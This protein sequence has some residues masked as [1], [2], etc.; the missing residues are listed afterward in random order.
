MKSILVCLLMW[1]MIAC[2]QD[3]IPE[4]LLLSTGQYLGPG[5]RAQG[6]AG[7]YTGI[8]DDY[9]A[10]WW[11]PAG[12]A[13]IKRIEI[14]GSLARSGFAN[15][16]AWNNL[17]EM[18]GK[19]S[20]IRINN[21]GLVL[22]VPVY[23]GALSFAFGYSQ[24]MSFDRHTVTGHDGEVNPNFNE[25]EKGRL[26]FWTFASAVDVSPN[27]ALG[28]GIQYWSGFDD[29]SYIDQYASQTPPQHEETIATDLG[30]WGANV[31]GLFRAGRYGRIGAMYQAPMSMKLDESW[32]IDS[33][34]GHFDYRMTYPA[35]FRVGGSLAPGRWL[36]A[37]DVE[38]RDWTSLEF[39]SATPYSGVS[40]AQANQ[41][42]KDQY[43]STTRFSLGG[44]YLFPM[45]GVRARAGYSFAPS[46]YRDAGGEDNKNILGLGLGLLVDRSVMLDASFNTTSYTEKVTQGLTEDIRSSAGLVT[47]SWRL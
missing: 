28:A 30:A 23:Q 26:G 35:V 36:V 14:Q 47:V 15:N 38:Y 43:K 17:P 32:V 5:A 12:L 42:I 29:Y 21:L 8:A 1:A 41:E 46:N 11:N 6:L 20:E 39:R 9:S 10:V 24:V 19:T 33:D 44:E 40:K 45:Y 16:A 34:D 25:L 7:T 18:E 22:P 31:G 13:Q 2:A 27:L 3:G 37:A 4:R